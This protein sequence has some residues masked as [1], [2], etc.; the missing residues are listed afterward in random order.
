MKYA[1]KQ[2]FPIE[3]KEQLLKTAS[4]VEKYLTRF[5]PKDRVA[6]ACNIEKRAHELGVYMDCDWIHNYSRVFNN[7]HAISPDFDKNMELRK[8]A[9]E[10]RTIEVEKK[11][12]KMNDV[13][14]KISSEI[15]TKTPLIVIDELFEFDKLAGLE[16]QWDKSIVDPVFT[17]Y[18]SL[19]NAKYDARI[20]FGHTTDYDLEKI[21]SIPTEIEELG[22]RL[23]K[24]NVHT[25][26]ADPVG[27]VD[28]MDVKQKEIMRNTV[29]GD[30]K[31]KY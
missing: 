7:Y 22:K 13:L 26:L 3:T 18:G 14:D 24:R 31:K 21:A 9:C 6:I 4:Y 25:F 8:H 17:V 10:N 27:T 20:M 29:E 16:Y 30:G 19:N 2:Q 11:Q 23:G 12:V 15:K 28:K 1:L 5:E